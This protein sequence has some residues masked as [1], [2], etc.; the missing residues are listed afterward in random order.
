MQEKRDTRWKTKHK[1]LAE[2]L[3]ERESG[4]KD[5]NEK[6]GTIERGKEREE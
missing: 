1:R 2:K 6:Y 5:E 4:S 3:K